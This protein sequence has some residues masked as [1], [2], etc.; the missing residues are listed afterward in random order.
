MSRPRAYQL[1]DAAQVAGNLSTIVDT[2]PASESVVRPLARLEP[3]EQR[4][5]W[6]EAVAPAS[7]QTEKLLN[8]GSVSEIPERVIRPLTR[9]ATRR[10][11]TKV[12]L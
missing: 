2:L 1:I 6:A 12:L 7:N 4:E 5:V 10:K 3:D 9:L 11:L 8:H